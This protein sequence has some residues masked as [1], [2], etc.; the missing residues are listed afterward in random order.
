MTKTRS[1]A[2]RKY[3]DYYDQFHKSVEFEIGS[4]VMLYT[5]AT[6][7]GLSYKLLSHWTGPYVVGNKIGAVTYRIRRTSGT[8]VVNIPVHVQRLRAYK[9][10]VSRQ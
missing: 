5:P 9:P 3:K 8:S 2:Q 6:K 4:Q 7:E 10:W 1:E